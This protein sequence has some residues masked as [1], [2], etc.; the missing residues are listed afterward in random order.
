MPRPRSEYTAQATPA[1][2]INR[3]PAKG[4]AEKPGSNNPSRPAKANDRPSHCSALKRS[5]FHKPW[6][7][8]LACTAPNRINA[9]VAAVRL[10]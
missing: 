2:S 5:P 1:A 6:P 8:M 3:A 10:R 7:I 4:G 9:P